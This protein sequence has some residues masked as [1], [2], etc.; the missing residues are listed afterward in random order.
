M[1][2]NEAIESNKNQPRNTILYITVAIL[3]ILTVYYLPNYLFLEKAT[4]DNASFLL[5]LFGMPVHAAI[6]GDGAYLEDIR[7]VKDC[8]GVQVVA[9][10]LGLLLPLPNTGWKKKIL[11]LAVISA[12]LYAANVLRIAVEFSL[13]YYGIL[14]WSLAHYPMSLLLGVVGVFVLVLVTDRLLPE[15]SEFLFRAFRTQET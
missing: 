12:I 13:V 9:V 6:I 7:I 10:F 8:T 11:T 4:A 3:I 2:N 14:P 1:P 5:N 15:F